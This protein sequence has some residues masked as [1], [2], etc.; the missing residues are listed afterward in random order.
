MVKG[1]F[2]AMI[3]KSVTVTDQQEKW[4]QSQIELGLYG[5]DSEVIR[6]AL[7]EKQLRMIEIE[8]LRDRLVLAENSGF[9]DQDPR[10]IRQAVKEKLRS[11]GKI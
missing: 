9:S 1:K 2:M 4:I 10:A 3:K 8:T 5:S 11:N 7:R 6:D